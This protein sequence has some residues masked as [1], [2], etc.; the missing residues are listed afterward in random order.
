MN[1]IARLLG[2]DPSLTADLLKTVN[3]ARYMLS[4]RMDNVVEAVKV[5]GIRGLRQM[6]YSYGTKRVLGDGSDNEVSKKLWEHSQ[7]TAFFAYAIARNV[8]KRKD[9]LDDVYVGAIL[10]DMGKIVFSNLQPQIVD[11]IKGFTE[12]KGIPSTVFEEMI[13]GVDHAEVGA[14][15]ADRWNFPEILV[16]AIR[17]HHAPLKAP[18][19]FRD[20]VSVVYVANELCNLQHGEYEQLDPRVL[21]RIGISS[22]GQ[23]AQIDERLSQ[24]YDREFARLQQQR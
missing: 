20:V 13:N 19:E 21:K 14:Q 9:M 22:S 5:V 3:S 17:Y 1:H 2:Q 10:H 15:L 11:Q 16:A 8:Y 4:R 23:L 24:Q 7:R 18:A 6:L 12:E